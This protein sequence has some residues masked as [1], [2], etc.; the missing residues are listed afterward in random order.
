MVLSQLGLFPFLS[1]A[2]S[3]NEEVWFEEGQELTLEIGDNETL[4]ISGEIY[5]LD[6]IVWKSGNENIVTTNVGAIEAVGIGRTY[7]TAKVV[8]GDPDASPSGAKKTAIAKC[9]VNVGNSLLRVATPTVSDKISANW[10]YSIYNDEVTITKYKGIDAEVVIPSEIEGKPVTKIESSIFEDKAV[11]RVEMPDSITEI[12][13][14]IFRDCNKLTEVILSN[15]LNELP[16]YTFDNCYRL[17]SIILP[18][19]L[20]QIFIS[21]FRDTGIKNL[22]IPK[23][24]KNI[25]MDSYF[26]PK[27]IT[28][29]SV[30]PD[31]QFY[32][33][34]D[35]MLVS[36]DKSILYL[37]PLGKLKEK[38]ILK[39]PNIIEEIKYLSAITSVGDKIT[40]FL[41]DDIE[42]IDDFGSVAKR[43]KRNL[44]VETSS[45]AYN[46]LKINSIPA[47]CATEKEFDEIMGSDFKIMYDYLA[48]NNTLIIEDYLGDDDSVIIPDAIGSQKITKIDTKIFGNNKISSISLPKNLQKFVNVFSNNKFEDNNSEIDVYS[49]NMR[50]IINNSPIDV[51]IREDQYKKRTCWYNQEYSG[52]TEL[53]KIPSNSTAY[54]HYLITYL[55]SPGIAPLYDD[56]GYNEEFTLREAPEKQ[57]YT[58]A[59]WQSQVWDTTENY[60]SKISK[61]TNKDI[62]V[63][64]SYNKNSSS[65]SSGG[66]SSGGG[67]GG[68]SSSGGGRKIGST[69]SSQN[70]SGNWKQ[71]EKGWWFQKTDG[72]YPKNEWIMNN[73]IWYHFDPEGYMQTGWI[74]LNNLKYF[75]NADG[76]MISNNWSLQNGKWF[77]FSSDGSM[78]T[79]WL[80]W[81]GLWY[82][83]NPDGTMAVNIIT[84]DGYNINGDGVWI[85]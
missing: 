36:K 51:P 73:N 44:W 35:G 53:K 9:I 4:T 76:S 82:Y 70:T 2:A 1:K 79:G 32:S 80:Q 48:D 57:G 58:F 19:S 47:N 66:S 50:K 7:V 61:G 11:T 28:S 65:S 71:D 49:N 85:Q 23:N 56:Y 77:F 31:N 29:Y 22:H 52:G 3:Y 37:Y 16:D 55:I 39:L 20:E 42:N 54:K 81:N 41:G 74:E 12:G 59:G 10:D 68:G 18:E 63:Y 14:G 62:K 8:I 15:S 75:L 43:Y 83:M 27:S 26:I 45:K 25:N 34:Y 33:D 40:V 60:I 84:P 24:V 38:E 21:A 17:E 46:L 78:K 67:G 6:S 64:A 13:Y 30:D 72:S 5:D 69:T